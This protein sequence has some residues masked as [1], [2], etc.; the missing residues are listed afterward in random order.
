MKKII[1]LNGA[2]GSGKD[3]IASYLTE[4]FDFMHMKFADPIRSTVKSMFNPDS[5]EDFKK[6][7]LAQGYTGRDFMIDFA[8]KLVKTKLGE[9][10]FADQLVKKLTDPFFHYTKRM[11]HLVISDLGFV[12]EADHLHV[13]YGGFLREREVP[14][15]F[16]I[17]HIDRPDVSFT[18]DSR[19]FIFRKTIVSHY[20]YNDSTLDNLFNQVKVLLDV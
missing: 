16:E 8:E 12:E 3:A 18:G 1:L 4:N 20:I 17:W 5:V 15:K 7:E 19:Y 13:K 10:F 2:G 14:Y 6:Q 11:K 9:N